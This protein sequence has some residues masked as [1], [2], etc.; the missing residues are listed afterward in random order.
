MGGRENCRGFGRV[1]ERN[2]TR[3]GSREEPFILAVIT[4][5]KP[6]HCVALE[7]PNGSVALSDFDSPHVFI[8]VDTFEVQ[9][10]VPGV[11]SPQ[12]IGLSDRRSDTSW[13]R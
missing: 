8:R 7:N 9:R 1:N 2:D 12:K 13:E 4:D 3:I 10:R 11:L 5:P 6:G